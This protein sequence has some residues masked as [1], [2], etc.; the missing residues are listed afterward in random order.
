LALPEVMIE[1]MDALSPLSTVWYSMM[2]VF[3][4]TATTN[5]LACKLLNGMEA[6]Y[7]LVTDQSWDRR[8]QASKEFLKKLKVNLALA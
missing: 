8:Q 6:Q 4:Q 2:C 5:G 3:T 1:R 7:G